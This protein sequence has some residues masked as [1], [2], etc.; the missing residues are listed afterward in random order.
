MQR[1]PCTL[2]SEDRAQE[3]SEIEPKAKGAAWVREDAREDARGRG[4]WM[5]DTPRRGVGGHGQS[6]EIRCS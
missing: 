6:A 3:S 4:V 5:W 2:N 1:T